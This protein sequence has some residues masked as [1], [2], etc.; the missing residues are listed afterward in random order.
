M[1]LTVRGALQ[2]LAVFVCML[3]GVIGGLVVLDY[4]Q[5]DDSGVRLIAGIVACLVI[6]LG[7]AALW[8]LM[9]CFIERKYHG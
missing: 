3:V 6:G 8:I 5:A 9:D 4:I 7:I 1:I 2:L